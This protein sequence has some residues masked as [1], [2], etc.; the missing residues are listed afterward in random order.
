MPGQDQD[1]PGDM[2]PIG[3]RMDADSWRGAR[4]AK[5]VVACCVVGGGRPVRLFTRFVLFS[6]ACNLELDRPSDQYVFN[7]S[8][9]K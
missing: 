5:V 3:R 1:I 9:L 2:C 7:N 4:D 6:F 8:F